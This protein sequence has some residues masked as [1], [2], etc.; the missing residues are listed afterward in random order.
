MEDTQ[1]MKR[2]LACAVDDLTPGESM[3]LDGGQIA[4]HRAEDGT[5]FAT[6][7]S[8][9]HE[10]WS[11]GSEGEIEGSELVCPLHMARFDLASGKP[12][13]LPATIALATYRVEIDDDQVYVVS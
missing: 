4:L 1:T 8:C 9:S 13:C 3:T 2:Q 11:L 5:F 12:L 10:K 6:A 7:D